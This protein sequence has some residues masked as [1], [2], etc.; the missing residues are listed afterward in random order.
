MT[1]IIGRGRLGQACA[2]Y[3]KKA[4]V[5]SRSQCDITTMASINTALDPRDRLIINTAAY[6]A[7]DDC[8]KNQKDA[9][10]I[11]ALGPL[12]LARWCHKNQASLIHISTDYVFDGKKETP[13][14]ESDPPN[15]INY[16]G[17]S[18][19][20]GEQQ[21]ISACDSAYIFRIQWLFGPTS[22][23][24]PDDFVVKIRDL[25]TKKSELTVINDQVG[26]PSYS[27]DIASALY[28]LFGDQ[29]SLE[30]GLYHL[31]ASGYAS[32]Y[33][34]ACASIQLP[35]RYP[36]RITPVSSAAYPQPAQRPLNSRLSTAKLDPIIRLRHWQ[37]ALAAYLLPAG[38]V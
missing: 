3:F 19:L 18:K 30:H 26:S 9:Y 31:R 7:V 24:R 37:A 13:Y 5:L 14:T 38:S 11:N 2:Q 25:A 12:H 35:P 34:L 20:I 15:P 29:I 32:W 4:R 21:V 27:L 23:G 10:A 36:V 1:V 17:Y 8:E 28:S 6:T 22:A 16:Y 33:S